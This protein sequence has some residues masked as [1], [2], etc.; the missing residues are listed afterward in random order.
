MRQHKSEPAGT[1]EPSSALL[2]RR[3]FVA[4]GRDRW[5][6]LRPVTRHWLTNVAIGVLIELLLHWVGHTLYWQPLVYAQ[7]YALDAVMRANAAVDPTPPFPKNRAP[8]SLALIDIDDAA[9]RSSQWGGGEPYRAPRQQLLALVDKAFE[10]GARQVVLDVVVE[11]AHRPQELAED[12]AFAGALDDLLAKPYFKSDPLKQL[13]L[14]RTLRHPLARNVRMADA[15]DQ[16]RELR[17]P[18]GYLSELRESPRIDAVVKNSRDRIVVAAPY[19]T[20]SSDRVLRDWQLLQAVCARDADPQVPGKIRVVP[21]V[22]LAVLARHVGVA[23]DM[24][25]GQRDS[26]GEAG[27]GG[28]AAQ[29]AQ[30]CTPFP[31]QEGA[32]P[33]TRENA[34]QRSGALEKQI[35]L[36]INASWRAMHEGFKSKGIDLG[37]G[38]KPPHA[39]SLANRVVFRIGDI[40]QLGQA[41]VIP[42]L[43]FLNGASPQS[44]QDRVVV[45]GQSYLEAGD[46]HITP[47]GEMSG[48]MVLVNAIDSMARHS[49]IGSPNGWLTFALALLLIVF[50]GYVFARWDSLVGTW[51]STG[52]AIVLLAVG[53]FYLFK[54]GVWLDFALPLLGIQAHRMV[55]SMEERAEHKRLAQLA[56]GG[57]H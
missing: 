33:N 45:I 41:Q 56:G 34:R 52:V 29:V 40:P 37:F 50:V 13:V 3:S 36:A 2:S 51:I 14:V 35:E 28:K 5:Q 42:A 25:P 38:D 1:L 20:Y 23:P 11:G 54:Y 22:Q 30:T 27:D 57:H 32:A 47:L 8:L 12:D 15:P 17:Y 48:G 43:A 19:F 44:L 4:R 16:L 7:N 21:S 18:E 10:K 46:R 53:S 24:L 6:R 55:K 31:M 39:Q 9:W 49:L 26:Q